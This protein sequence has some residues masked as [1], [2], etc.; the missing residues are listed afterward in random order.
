MAL[1][2]RGLSRRWPLA[3]GL[4]GLCPGGSFPRGR[5]SPSQGARG[6]RLRARVLSVAVKRRGNPRQVCTT[7]M[8]IGK[9]V[10][11][12]SNSGFGAPR[13]SSVLN[14]FTVSS[15]TVALAWE[16]AAGEADGAFQAWPLI[17]RG[18]R[19]KAWRVDMRSL[20]E[21][22]RFDEARGRLSWARD[23]LANRCS[24]VHRR[25]RLSMAVRGVDLVEP[26]PL[27]VKSSTGGY[28]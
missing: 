2:R 18:G 6:F 7:K 17:W 24:T 15:A 14:G 8:T 21:R 1:Q 11:V 28:A 20:L 26:S 25:P 10:V 9:V 22:R 23:L 5:W 13:P 12:R 27:A 3:T 4:L 16:V 19:R